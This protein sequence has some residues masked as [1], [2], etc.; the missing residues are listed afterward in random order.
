LERVGELGYSRFMPSETYD[1]AILGGGNAAF[2]ATVPTREAGLKVLMVE[3][4]DL[5]GTCPN[6]G[7]TPKKVLVAA[8]HALHEI[9]QAH[10][11]GIKVGKPNLDWTA[12]IDREKELIRGIPDRLAKTLQERGVDLIRD[13]GKF[14]GPNAIEAAGR[15]IEAKHVV[16]ATGSKPRPLPIPGAELMITSDEVLSER[17][18]PG[19][20]VFVGGGVIALEFS[21]VYRRAGAEVTILEVLPRLLP[22]LDADAVQQV[23]KESERLGIRVHTGVKVK[24]VEKVGDKLR[25]TFEK[26]GKEISV[27]SDRVVNGAGRIANV[28]RLDL[29]A[30]AI[31]HDGFKIPLDDYLRAKSNPAVYVCGDVTAAPQLS[32]IA[33]YEGKIVGRNI[34]EGAKHKPDYANIPSCVFTVPALATVGLSEEKAKEK[35]LKT[36]VQVNDMLSWFSARTFAE[37]VAWSKII[38]EEATDRIVGAH[39][40]GHSGE[41]LINLFGLAMQHGITASQIRDFVFAYPTFSADIKSML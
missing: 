34:V 40:V 9:G 19:S 15:R 4:R 11:H 12:L 1:V 29:D 28:D 14:V 22:A 36:R 16:I 2:G 33:T 39:F 30:A 27:D 21:H 5:G 17:T 41:E 23:H 18:L 31:T 38:V 3:G 8:V 35:G 7:C 13:H 32:P 20:V 26:D 25:T 37:T 10:V 24:R 6:R